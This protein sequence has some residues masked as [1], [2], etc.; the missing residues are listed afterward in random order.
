MNNPIRFGILGCGTIAPTHARAIADGADLRT[1][2][3]TEKHA[4]WAA[5]FREEC[6]RMPLPALRERL[7]QEVGKVF[8]QVL[9]DCGVFPYTAEGGA[10][11]GRYLT[12][13]QNHLK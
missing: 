2:P 12:D 13:L 10:A 6:A 7:E 1:D 4:V 8:E 11:F 5:S 3:Q 9:C